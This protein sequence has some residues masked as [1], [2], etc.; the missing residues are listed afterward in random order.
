[1]HKYRIERINE[2]IKEVLSEFVLGEIKDP[3]AGLVT[4]VSVR[5]SRDLSTA[6]VHFSV[7][8]DQAQRELTQ[9]ILKGASGAMRHAVARAIDVS[10]APELRWVYDDSLDRAFR[11]EEMLRQ[12]GTAPAAAAPPERESPGADDDAGEDLEAIED[13]DDLEALEELDRE[14]GED[15]PGENEDK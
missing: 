15:L 11:L 3:R 12:T 8:G 2:I 14:T 4:I 13:L 6:R 7:M 9:R 1:M 5:V 10:H